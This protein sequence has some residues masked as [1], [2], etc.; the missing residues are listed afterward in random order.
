ML[1]NKK[2]KIAIIARG[3]T[4]GGVTRVINNLL[5]EFENTKSQ[6]FTFIL[7]TDDKNFQKKFKNIKVVFIPPANKL[8]WDYFKSWIFLKK[9]KPN[10]IIYPKNIIPLT[11][12]FIKS[13]KINIVH[14]LAYFE[15]KLATYPFW[16]TLYMKLFMKISCIIANITVV[17]SLATKKDLINRLKINSQ[18][19]KV[20]HWG[21]EEKFKK[22]NNPLILDNILKKYQISKP[23]LFYAGSISPR[24]NLLRLLKA[25]NLIK[26]KIPHVL[27]ITG[28][29]RLKSKLI[30]KYISEHLKYRVKI[31]GYISEEELIAL[32]NTAD[33]CLY[34]SLYE[35]FGLP[36]LEAQACGC[37][38]ITS[39]ISCMPEVAGKGAI[40]VNPYNVKKIADAIEKLIFD[41]KLKNKI[42]KNGKKNKEFFTREKCK[43]QFLKTFY[44]L[45]LKNNS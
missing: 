35:G 13:K 10:I 17:P 11:H 37:P 6:N 33:I 15:K 1:K 3:L 29:S 24:K 4:R 8:Y 38:V 43:I 31:L 41:K 18:K 32:Y 27:V 34:P 30:I 19:I 44:D 20:I 25:F 7:F 26:N 2:I 14:D 5:I 22:I 16:D 9:E 39:N 40:L 42:I 36:I 21:I 23:F 12:I 45:S 28:N